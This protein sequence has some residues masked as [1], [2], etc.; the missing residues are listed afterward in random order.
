MQDFDLTIE[1]RWSDRICMANELDAKRAQFLLSTH[2][3]GWPSLTDKWVQAGG[4][5]AKLDKILSLHRGNNIVSPCRPTGS[6]SRDVSMWRV[7]I[8]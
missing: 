1:R 4:T 2:V 8:C 7:T 6:P 3:Q 5:K